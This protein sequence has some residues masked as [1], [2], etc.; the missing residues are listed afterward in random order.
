MKKKLAFVDLTNFENWP[1][2]GMLEYELAILPILAE[3]YDLEIWGY[4]VNGIQ[5][6]PLELNGKLYEIN[7]CGNCNTEKRLVPNSWRG[8]SLLNKRIDKGDYDIVYAHTAS[9]IIGA[10]LKVNNKTKLV[11]HQHGLNH[12]VDYSLMSLLQRPFINR[13]QKVSD[14][15]FVVSDKESVDRFAAKQGKVK[16]KYVPIGSPVNLKKFNKAGI[17]KRIEENKGKVAKNFLY[18]GRLST[19]KNVRTLLRAFA[20]YVKNVNES[21]IF[22]I[23]GT[24]EE[25][26]LLKQI[27]REENIEKN[28]NLLGNV[29]HG[30]IYQYLESADVFMTASGGEGCSV[31][32]LEGFAAGLPVICGRVPG[33]E[34]QVNESIGIFVK[35]MTPESFFEAMKDM[36]SK[37][38]ELSCN[39]LEHIKNYAADKIGN[40]I[41]SEIDALFE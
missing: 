23:A 14:L 21:A 13:A 5:P 41:V 37:R 35:D 24:G 31:S 28:V 26:D 20:L 12:Q 32:V 40:L 29:K 36:D 1:M 17:E 2:G 8:L 6:K 25:F 16:A 4:S 18:T 34:K 3:H 22:N 15:I 39:C 19:F 27:C 9:C 10:S 33:L 38:Y 30:D 7:I 11:Y